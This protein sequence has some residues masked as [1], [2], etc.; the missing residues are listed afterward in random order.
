MWD[1]SGSEE[2][3]EDKG[4]TDYKVVEAETGRVLC[5]FQRRVETVSGW[6]GGRNGK[7]VQQARV[8]KDR[9]GNVLTDARNVTG[10]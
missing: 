3:E 9:D 7:D 4:R 1:D 5:G 10:R 6:S 2:D 8:I